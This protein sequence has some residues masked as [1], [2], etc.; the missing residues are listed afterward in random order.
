MD[1]KKINPANGLRALIDELYARI[2]RV[3]QIA[4]LALLAGPVSST[5]DSPVTIAAG[6]DPGTIVTSVTITPKVT[7]KIQVIAGAVAQPTDPGGDVGNLVISHGALPV[8]GDFDGGGVVVQ[9]SLSPDSGDQLWI[10]V[11]YGTSFDVSLAAFP[12]NEPVTINLAMGSG[13][14]FLS[15][16]ARGA[17]LTAKEIA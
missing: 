6:A 8:A 13:S 11:E 12:L 4:Q 1:Q 17:Q 9:G 10:L 7:G 3:S 14:G 15:V 2:T 5:N 16:P